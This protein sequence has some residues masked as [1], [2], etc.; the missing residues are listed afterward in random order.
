MSQLTHWKNIHRSL[1]IF[2]SDQL[3]D[4]LKQAV[5]CR[6]FK[7]DISDFSV[8]QNTKA[9]LAVYELQLDATTMLIHVSVSTLYTLTGLL[10]NREQ[11]S[12]RKE[13]PLTLTELFVGRKIVSMASK[14]LQESFSSVEFKKG[15]E[16]IHEIHAFYPDDVM[17]N[18]VY[19]LKLNQNA[20]GTVTFTYLT[21]DTKE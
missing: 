19:T 1:G 10:L 13:G 20:I 18:C 11:S 12:I 3:T 16:N 15:T 14:R 9:Q 21:S 17:E 6:D 2:L 5:D 8:V 7:I 4:A